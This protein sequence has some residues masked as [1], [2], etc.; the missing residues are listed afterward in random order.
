MNIFIGNLNY[1]VREGD[2]EQVFK[3]FG[4]VNSARVITDRETGRS[5]GFGFVEMADDSEA[6]EAIKEL[7]GKDLGGRAMVVNEAKPRN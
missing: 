6:Q 4:D 5:K 2:L 7:N 1:K 3:Q